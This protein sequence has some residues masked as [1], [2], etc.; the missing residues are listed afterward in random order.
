MG[1]VE[2]QGETAD[3]IQKQANWFGDQVK[4]ARKRQ[5]LLFTLR[6][7]NL[8]NQF[9]RL[10]QFICFNSPPVSL[11]LCKKTNISITLQW[12]QSINIEIKAA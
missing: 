12:P 5:H 1:T 7:Y 2:N 3:V 4:N 10:S 11:T 8:L 9:V 6:W